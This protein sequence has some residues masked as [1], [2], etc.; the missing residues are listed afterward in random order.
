MSDRF[1]I[2][3]EEDYSNKWYKNFPVE[4][5]KSRIMFDIRS[6]KILIQLKFTNISIKT[7]DSLNCCIQCFDVS[8][9]LIE[10]ISE[11]IF[12]LLNSIPNS[13]FGDKSPILANDKRIRKIIVTINKVTFADGTI[14]ENDGD[15]KIIDVN[16]PKPIKFDDELGEQL[17]IC[18]IPY[19]KV[20]NALEIND[21][22]WR[23]VCGR[24]NDF[25]S[26]ICTDCKAEKD[27]LET[28]FSKE[29][30][31]EE[32]N[33]AISIKNDSMYQ[34]ALSL[35]K[36]IN[37][38]NNEANL[39]KAIELYNK[40]PS[41]KDA[42]HRSFD[43][44]EKLK[45]IK[46]QK[47]NE[48]MLREMQIKK[49]KRMIRFITLFA[50]SLTVIT[51]GA[52][53][54]AL[55]IIPTIRYEQALRCFNENNYEQAKEIFTDLGAFKD[56]N[57]FSTECQKYI[58]YNNAK[59]LFDKENY[60]EAR[61]IFIS[62]DNFENSEQM[63]EECEKGLEYLH[64]KELYDSKNYEEA[65]EEFK[66]LG[67]FNNSDEMVN[68]CKYE[69]A[70]NL[71]ENKNYDDA[72]AE[73]KKLDSFNNSDEMVL[74]CKY[75]KAI[76]LYNQND[77]EDALDI[78][79]ELGEYKNCKDNVNI[80]KETLYK[81]AL[82]SVDNCY[83]FKA[84]SI[85]SKISEYRDS[86]EQK[87]AVIEKLF[88]YLP[89]NTISASS[90]ITVAILKDGSVI[91]TQPRISGDMFNRNQSDTND[92]NNV[93]A[94]SAGFLHTV[95]LK[96]D[97]TVIAV[98][99]NDENQCDVSNW[100]DIIAVE[101]GSSHTVGLHSDGTVIAVG[102]NYNG[103]CD[104]SGW[105]NIVAISSNGHHTVG[106]RA[107]GTAVATGWNHEGQCNV[108]R[109]K[110]IKQISAGISHTVGLK[111]DGTVVAVGYNEYGQCDVSNWTNIVSVVANGFTT[112]GI[113]ADGTVV[114]T[115]YNEYGLCDKV[116]KWNDIVEI[117]IG[118][119]YN[120]F[121]VKSD[122]SMVY[123]SSTGDDDVADWKDIKTN[124]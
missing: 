93:I 124:N 82:N 84:Y 17:K 71:L 95:G 109:W 23:C 63:V 54:T 108:G 18:L 21:D 115:G 78:F 51:I 30:L 7:I 96:N 81:K 19:K 76:N 86:Q 36:S 117:D 92:W 101:A 59:N 58:T 38:T 43:C 100:S 90:L 16:R 13:T 74:Q 35:E 55:Y 120:V 50:S 46:L 70:K 28:I 31:I 12:S 62:L 116:Q 44:S 77:L 123:V 34:E 61:D 122:G 97:K 105:R 69:I 99:H 64:A 67:T 20:H 75:E 102:D 113:K 121:G 57:Q 33:K 85:F 2:I 47:E 98:G 5:N 3:S 91:S 87:N 32:R 22:Y 60:S 41:W 24:I 49:Q 80:I 25:N 94:V 39:I 56:S 6:N 11:H 45:A 72:I 37:D 29:Y 53:T 88:D 114:A 103:E 48:I 10:T 65:V 26:N 8:N 111:T 4:L 83:Y 110:N 68:Q 27:K 73:F 118:D 66:K 52:F 42:T 1:K 119:E 9:Q 107:N 14:W 104:V 112:I 40:I 89:K 106:L 79:V 15:Y